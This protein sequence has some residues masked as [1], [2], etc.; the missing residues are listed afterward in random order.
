MWMAAVGAEQ[1][2]EGGDRGGEDMNALI[3]RCFEM[4]V[5]VSYCL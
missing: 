1:R 3:N 4:C 5:S 2:Y